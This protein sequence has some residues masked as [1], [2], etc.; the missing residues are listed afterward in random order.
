MKLHVSNSN[1]KVIFYLAMFT[2]YVIFV[3]SIISIYNNS[4]LALKYN[5]YY[6]FNFMVFIIF[7]DILSKNKVYIKYIFYSLTIS[8]LI[9]FLLMLGGYGRTWL[10]YQHILFFNNPHQLGYYSLLLASLLLLV[11]VYRKTMPLQLLSIIGIAIYLSISALSISSSL[12]IAVGSTFY[13]MRQTKQKS[14]GF[15]LIV[16]ISIILSLV[17]GKTIYQKVVVSNPYINIEEKIGSKTSRS[18]GWQAGRGYDTLFEDPQ[19]LILGM[20]EFPGRFHNEFHSILG[21][22]L[23]SYGIVGLSLL[24]IFG[25]L[26]FKHKPLFTF[27]YFIPILMYGLAHNGIRQPFLWIYLAMVLSLFEKNRGNNDA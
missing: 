27:Y 8:L 3:N 7:L 5:L 10:G 4:A 14:R 6:L 15:Y 1:K 19:Y 17:I 16:A 20:G 24:L 2:I 22:I 21:N 18:G 13:V 9:Q 25:Y 26:V 11:G 23:R 12:A